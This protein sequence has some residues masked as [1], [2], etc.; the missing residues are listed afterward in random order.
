MHGISTKFI[1]CTAKCW[2]GLLPF[3]RGEI[4]NDPKVLNKCVN[5]LHRASS[6]STISESKV[7]ETF[8]IV[9]MP[10]IGLLPFLPWPLK[11]KTRNFIFSHLLMC[12]CPA[13]G[14]FH[15]YP[16]K[17][18]SIMFKQNCVNALHRA[19]SISTM[20]ADIPLE[21]LC[22]CQCPASGFFHFYLKYQIPITCILE[23]VNALNRAS[24][25]STR[26]S[27]FV[28]PYLFMCQCPES[29]F[30]HFYPDLWNPLIL[31]G[32][33][34]QFCKPI[35]VSVKKRL[36]MTLF[37]VFRKNSLFTSVIYHLSKWLYFLL[38][39]LY[40]N[41]FFYHLHYYSSFFLIFVVLS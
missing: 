24:S 22:M 41:I 27:R 5:A 33:R 40:Y 1:V 25:I 36:K 11:R 3:L 21:R 13:S 23:C 37:L 39:H 9:S 15:F 17:E 26:S 34:S 32:C 30:F 2:V 31:R 16:I 19:S 38:K 8:T 28:S 20:F 35:S 6:I 29:G 10:C 14:F 12:Q 7:K 4:P 18:V